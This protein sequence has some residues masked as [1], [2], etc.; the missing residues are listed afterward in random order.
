MSLAFAISDLRER[1][2]FFDVVA[3]RIWQAWWKPR[4]RPLDHI[5]SRL[6]EN[7]NAEP[8]PLGLVAHAGDRFLGTASVIA[9]DLDERP[10]FSPW[11]AAVWVEPD[12]RRH[13]IGA[14]LVDHATEATFSLG[15]TRVYLCA[16]R[17]RAT[18]YQRLGWRRIEENV[19]RF[20]LD[21]YIRDARGFRHLPP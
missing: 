10:Q 8:I 5:S 11:V 21:V 7:L 9:F 4:G 20:A 3:D 19:G 15:L 6:R 14:A 16:R 2:E 18:F 17:E 13:G 1:S 12:A